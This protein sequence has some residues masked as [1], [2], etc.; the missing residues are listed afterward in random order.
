[1]LG[2]YLGKME[3]VTNYDNDFL[4]SDKQFKDD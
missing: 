1:M 4:F 2:N 3:L